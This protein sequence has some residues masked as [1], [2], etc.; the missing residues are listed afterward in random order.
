MVLLA[1][2]G[3][4]MSALP[5]VDEP[6]PGIRERVAVGSTVWNIQKVTCNRMMSGPHGDLSVNRFDDMLIRMEGTVLNASA[7]PCRVPRIYLKTASGTQFEVHPRASLGRTHRLLSKDDVI[8]PGE[9]IVFSTIFAVPS[10]TD[11]VYFPAYD[12]TDLTTEPVDIELVPV[13]VY[14]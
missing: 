12:L 11:L 8:R 13:R 10:L 3:C 4:S 1:A 14:Y 9:T 2:S 7:R 5:F 6:P